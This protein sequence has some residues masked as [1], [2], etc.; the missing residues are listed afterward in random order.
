MQQVTFNEAPRELVQVF[1]WLL[2]T[3]DRRP[4]DWSPGVFLDPRLYVCFTSKLTLANILSRSNNMLT[5]PAL[6]A[7]DYTVAYCAARGLAAKVS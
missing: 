5:Q 7:L 2:Q 4:V 1:V 6:Y 3:S